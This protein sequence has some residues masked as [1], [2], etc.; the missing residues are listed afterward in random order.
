MKTFTRATQARSTVG[1]FVLALIFA[2]VLGVSA[3]GPAY[4]QGYDRRAWHAEHDRYW[5]ERHAE[6][7]RYWRERHA[8][9]HW[10][11]YPYYGYEAYPPPIY[12][13][14]PGISLFFPFNIH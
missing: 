1:R 8:E 13:P 6:H 7:D 4:G 12:A 3:T 11:T 2:A 10:R 9:R 14:S 5:R